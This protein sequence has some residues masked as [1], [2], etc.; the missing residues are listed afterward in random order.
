MRAE[1]I[2]ESLDLA[3]DAE[4]GSPRFGTGGKAAARGQ[5][6]QLP[7]AYGDAPALMFRLF[8]RFADSNTGSM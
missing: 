5:R 1:S 3:R 6:R 8:Q 7:L 4:D 2:R